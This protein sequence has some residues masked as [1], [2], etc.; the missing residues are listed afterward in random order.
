MI[1]SISMCI[2]VDI[3]QHAAPLPFLPQHLEE[4]GH[5]SAEIAAVMGGYYWSGFV[6][7][8]LITAYQIHGVLVRRYEEDQWRLL[9]GHVLK[10]MAGLFAGG[11]TLL[12]EAKA[13]KVDGFTMH[14][15]HLLCRLVQGFVG[16]FLFFYA[17][18]LSVACFKGSQQIF[19]L[20]AT[21]ISLNVAEVFGP[22]VGATIF[23]Q[24]GLAEAYYVLA[25][26]S[27]LNSAFLVGV[28]FLMPTDALD[29]DIVAFP[30]ETTA[31]LAHNVHSAPPS[32]HQTPTP[33]PKLPP[34][35]VSGALPDTSPPAGACAGNRMERLTSVLTNKVLIASCICIAPA[36]MV[37]SSMEGIL[38]LFGAGQGYTEFEV[39]QLF[40]AVALGFIMSATLL[41]YVWDNMSFASRASLTGG[42]LL[43]L[44]GMASILLHSY[45]ADAN[46]HAS[47]H[48]SWIAYLN[49]SN[50]TFFYS[51][52]VTYGVLLGVTHTAPALYL[53]EVL[54][55]LEEDSQ[56][57][58]AA[59]GLW[60][61]GWEAGGSLGFI[62]AGVAS[63]DS[64]REEQA[65]LTSLGMCVVVSAAV[66]MAMSYTARPS[67]TKGLPDRSERSA[68]AH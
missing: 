7:G 29:S 35:S 63:T 9:R 13:H 38:P 15:V 36:A 56:C 58:Q 24:Y 52:L 1:V 3:L 62:A 68:L 41:G 26:L 53:G 14:Q 57:K 11:A 23:S 25:G 33:S 21:T 12:V 4:H 31:L 19:A 50:H 65:V 43:V 32:R 39:G 6:G 27:V 61:T 48:A 10:L 60:N 66:F 55:S 30:E 37:K 22:F 5:D 18:L 46:I 34:V 40:T 8:L 16:A 28:Y 45:G 20:T 54:D 2:C 67:A 59:N 44:G 42:S 49:G 64:W 47:W 17:Y 51:L